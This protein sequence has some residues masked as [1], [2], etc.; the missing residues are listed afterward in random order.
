[1]FLQYRVLWSTVHESLLGVQLISKGK[2]E[3]VS[4]NM[5]LYGHTQFGSCKSILSK[6]K[7]L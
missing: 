7:L 2:N 1:M 3:T 5:K 6:Y 4:V